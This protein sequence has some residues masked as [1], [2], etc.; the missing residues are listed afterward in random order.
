MAANLYA[1]SI[2]GED[3]LANVSLEKNLGKADAPVTGHIRLLD[4]TLNVLTSVIW[5]SHIENH[6]WASIRIRAKSQG[7]ALSLGDK[8]NQTQ[9]SR[10]VVLVTF[11]SFFSHLCTSRQ[12]HW[13]MFSDDF[14]FQPTQEAPS[15]SRI[16]GPLIELASQYFPTSDYFEHFHSRSVGDCYYVMTS[17]WLG[18]GQDRSSRPFCISCDV[19]RH[20]KMYLLEYNTHMHSLLTWCQSRNQPPKPPPAVSTS[21]CWL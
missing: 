5:I 13:T 19:M 21:A 2:F 9:K 18:S 16:R 3:A 4:W 14:L 11:W 6:S 7:M 20:R 15:S 17:S 1:K 12:Q 8:I 10:W